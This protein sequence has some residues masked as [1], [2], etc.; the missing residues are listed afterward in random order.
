MVYEPG[1][2]APLDSAAIMAFLAPSAPDDLGSDGADAL[3]AIA[4]QAAALNG[5]VQQLKGTPAPAFDT[6]HDDA[7]VAAA[8]TAATAIDQGVGVPDGNDVA[9]FGETVDQ[10]H[11]THDDLVDTP[12]PADVI[13]AILPG[14]YVTLYDFEGKGVDFTKLTPEQQQLVNQIPGDTLGLLPEPGTRPGGNG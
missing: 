5:L 12:D 8:A 1:P 10:V 9:N 4:D 7:L 11:T 14:D 2:I 13:N 3:S 6:S